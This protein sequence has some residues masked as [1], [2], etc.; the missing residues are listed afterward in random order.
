ME[1]VSESVKT[2]IPPR[3]MAALLAV[4]LAGCNAASPNASLP[5]A[6]ASLHE[7]FAKSLPQGH[8][9]AA[10]LVVRV[11]IPHQRPP[12]GRHY[13][14]AATKGM[15]MVFAGPSNV[16]QVINLTR[17]DPR[18]VGTP[19]T[20]TIAVDLLP[21]KYTSNVNTYDQ[22]PVAGSIPI[23]AKVLSTAQGVSISIVA[24]YANHFG[25]VLDGV[26]ASLAVSGLP[27]ATAGT[28]FANPQVFSVV[29]KDADGDVIVGTYAVPVALGD[30]DTTGATA[31]ATTGADNPP[32]GELFSSSD[33][34]TLAYSGAG[35]APATI[36]A[37]ATGAAPGFAQFIPAGVVVVTRNSDS[38]P[39]ATGLCPSGTS[40]DLRWAMCNASPGNYIA[41]NC[42]N[43][44]TIV[45]GAALPPIVQDQT[46]DGG[47]FGRV[48][49]DG[50]STYRAFWADSGSVTIANLQIQN[51]KALGG[52]GGSGGQA[53]GG[54]A[55]LGGALFVNAAHV[56]V[57]D[58]YFLNASAIGGA[59]GAG[60]VGSGD[61]G[62]G[63]L[64]G[65]GG[66]GN[67]GGGAGG[68]GVL[69]NG[70]SSTSNNGGSG[71]F[72]GGGGGAGD[73]SPGLGAVG[74]AGYAGNSGGGAGS[75]GVP[76][77]PGTG[78]D[79]GF[80]GGGGGTGDGGNDGGLGGF[81]GGGGGG[82]G[83]GNG[84]PG[85]GGGSNASGGALASVS[86]GSSGDNAGGG[87]AAAGPAIFVKSGTLTTTD[88][89]ASGSAASGGIGDGG[90]ANPG[91]ADATPTFN[92]FGT[93]NAST[94][95]GPV[96]SA[97]SNAVPQSVHTLGKQKKTATRYREKAALTTPF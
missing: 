72:G 55:G 4:L 81:G 67:S 84:G 15:T 40:G 75:N 16:T 79:G 32:S 23:G 19:L 76:A 11:R 34:A 5:N 92:Y 89:G 57:I 80:G 70:A 52:S 61:G 90:F 83:G 27:V 28:A 41:F 3:T 48:I 6:A 73:T 56:S 58:D 20:C 46:I 91:T 31:I 17:A 13:I 69:G 87:G 53:G 71:G 10:R 64:G 18:C 97:L 44:C 7:S 38:S 47:S 9:R 51:A 82:N 45:L 35:I 33:A 49:I 30:N 59:G 60:A 93:V 85:G 74:G 1:P 29:A 12:R 22:A 94:I 96:P 42:G 78:G 37:F 39:G 25:I 43:P 21:G 50:A 54:G 65:N 24:G 2:A 68:G 86:G 26:P 14:S 36:V 66:N 62:G 77:D 95:P 88:S 8:R 63:G